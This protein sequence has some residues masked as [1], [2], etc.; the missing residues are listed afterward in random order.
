M[1]LQTQILVNKPK[2]SNAKFR[3]Y[4]VFKKTSATNIFEID[5]ISNNK[6]CEKCGSISLSSDYNKRKVAMP[7]ERSMDEVW[8]IAKDNPCQPTI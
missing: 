6:L 7:W 4:W 2:L 1:D 3:N 8:D 5:C